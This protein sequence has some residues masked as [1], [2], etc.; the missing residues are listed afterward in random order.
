MITTTD[1]R[2]KL[3]HFER[4]LYLGYAKHRIP[5]YYSNFVPRFRTYFPASACCKEDKPN[6]YPVVFPIDK[7]VEPDCPND[8]YDVDS[9]LNEA[10]HHSTMT[11]YLLLVIIVISILLMRK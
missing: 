5:R 4:P 6:V 2:R 1:F 8:V 3:L 11:W 10:S 9:H 7:V